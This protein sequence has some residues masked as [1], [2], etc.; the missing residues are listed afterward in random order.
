MNPREIEQ[1]GPY[2]V[3]EFLAEGGM[4]WVFK[5][6]DPKFRVHR[7]LKM[8]K[9]QAAQGDEFRR[10]ESEAKLLA[11]IDHPNLVTIFDLGQDE[12]T[13][14]HY[15]TMTFVDGA[16]L[17]DSEPLRPEAAISIFLDVLSALERLHLEGIVHRDIK[18]GNILVMSDGRVL[19]GDLGIAREQ[20]SL[21]SLTRTGMALGSVQ[22][23]SPE[24][25]RGEQVSPASDVFS[26]GLALYQ[27][28]TGETIYEAVDEVDA[29]SGEQVLMYLGALLHS[30]GELAFRF[31]RS[32]PRSL[33][34]VIE[35]ACRFDPEQ[36]YPDAG[37]LRIALLEA[38]HAAQ[39]ALS[40]G[41]SRRWRGLTIAVLLAL[42]AAG[43]WGAWRLFERSPAIP[44]V[45]QAA[46]E[47]IR[48]PE[49]SIGVKRS[50]VAQMG[51]DRSASATDVLL[52]ASAESS[53]QV[54]VDA[55]KSLAQR[56]DE[57]VAGRL[58]ALLDSPEFTVRAW[59][60]RAL[61]E[62]GWQ[63][64]RPAL[65]ARLAREVE[66]PVQ[67][68]LQQAIERLEARSGVK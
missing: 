44:P 42:T 8:L 58:I 33:Q 21:I 5:V 57:R 31:P 15:Y 55:V 47:R 9:P 41:P 23:M 25:A 40:A 63:P 18:P 59:S 29:S 20:D 19:L 3:V 6:E 67:R 28:L 46:I 11:R 34:R 27:V 35:K 61:G 26:I 2:P 65:E 22:Y 52:A 49:V 64:A 36:R 16:R 4:A 54:A 60:A 32:V 13:G 45:Y 51:A 56:T 30:G 43:A 50:L 38:R 37:A 48:D 10:F 12:Q 66:A 53:P 1:I 17:A 14:C 68:Q 39:N 62:A 24:Q 7:A